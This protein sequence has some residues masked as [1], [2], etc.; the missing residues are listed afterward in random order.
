[1]GAPGE[2]RRGLRG[3][4]VG[5]GPQRQDRKVQWLTGGARRPRSSSSGGGGEGSARARHQQVRP[6]SDG[7]SGYEEC[8]RRGG[9]RYSSAVCMWRDGCALPRK[10]PGARQCGA[11]VSPPPRVGGC[12]G[13]GEGA[14]R[15]PGAGWPSPALV[16]EAGSGRTPPS[17]E[18]PWHKAVAGRRYPP[19]HTTL[20]PP[21]GYSHVA[22]EL[23]TAAK[24]RGTNAADAQTCSTSARPL[25]GSG[26][27][28]PLH[29]E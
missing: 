11:R 27:R 26:A 6:A 10:G 21:R 12:K 24:V 20:G 5:R 3:S 7:V 16:K 19:P 23:P 14:A 17:R 2:R 8:H 25:G 28:E 13:W 1:M 9:E 22:H 29:A 18:G 15:K 4:W